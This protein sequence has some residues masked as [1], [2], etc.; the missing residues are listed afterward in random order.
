MR[1]HLQ[2]GLELERMGFSAQ[3]Q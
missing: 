2:H 1:G 3:V